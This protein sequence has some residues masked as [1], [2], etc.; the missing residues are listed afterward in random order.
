MLPPGMRASPERHACA[1]PSRLGSSA[2]SC[3]Y[4]ISLLIVII[5]AVIIIVIIIIIIINLI[6]TAS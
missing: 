6:L 4:I 2:L 5:I 1:A 3:F